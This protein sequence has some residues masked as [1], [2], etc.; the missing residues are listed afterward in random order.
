MG[1]EFHT[2]SVPI[3]FTFCISDEGVFDVSGVTSGF[4][5]MRG[6]GQRHM[7]HCVDESCGTYLLTVFK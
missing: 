2:N 6:A 4:H 5:E 7:I 1:S 3:S